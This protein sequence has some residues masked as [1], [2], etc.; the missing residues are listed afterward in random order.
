MMLSRRAAW[1]L[2]GALVCSLAQVAV[3]QTIKREPAQP[4]RTVDGAE[5]YLRYCAPCHGKDLKG[6][7][8]AASAFKVP[9]TD[10]TTFAKRHGGKFSH[11]DLE[12]NI[13]SKGEPVPAHGSA[14]MPIWG[15][16]FKSMSPD[17][18]NLTLRI[19]NLVNYI[20]SMQVK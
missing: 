20:E 14:D 17:D 15:P 8:P 6:H 19:S 12:A 2:A 5:N 13:T 11:V 7:G 18:G 3:A 4:L 1:V 9:P 16:I 10:L